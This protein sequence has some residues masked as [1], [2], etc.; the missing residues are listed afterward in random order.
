M[1]HSVQELTE[2]SKE[3]RRTTMESIV[4]AVRKVMA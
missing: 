4:A 3:A 2:L 1:R